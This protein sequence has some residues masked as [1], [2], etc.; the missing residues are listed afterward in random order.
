MRCSTPYSNTID[1]PNP[2]AALNVDMY[3]DYEGDDEAKRTRNK[4]KRNKWPCG[5]LTDNGHVVIPIS[6][7]HQNLGRW[8]L[9]AVHARGGAVRFRAS[10]LKMKDYFPIKLGFCIAVE[11]A[12]VSFH[13][14]YVLASVFLW[15]VHLTTNSRTPQG[16]TIRK[17]IASLSEHPVP[18]LRF[19][20][21]QLY[22]LLS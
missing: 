12:Q 10:K 20:W 2:P 5:F 7:S 15:S 9:K 11:K 21:E 17:V 22:V 13:R 19:R 16:R 3:H 6:I 14:P 18:I 4:C 1:L 8:S